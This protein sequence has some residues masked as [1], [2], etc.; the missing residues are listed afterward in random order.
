MNGFIIWGAFTAVVAGLCFWKPNPTRIFVGLF[1]AVMGLGIHGTDILTN[2]QAYVDFAR[3]APIPL[4]RDIGLALTEPNPRAFGVFMLVFETITSVLILSRGWYVKLGLLAGIAFLL[5]I[6]P[7]GLEEIPNAILAVGM[8]SL[9]RHEYSS[10]VMTMLTRTIRRNSTA[11]IRPRHDRAKRR[12]TRVGTAR[13]EMRDANGRQ[14][15]GARGEWLPSLAPAPGAHDH[16]EDR[17]VRA[18]VRVPTV[19]PKASQPFLKQ[20]HS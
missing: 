7:L 1:F 14:S 9:M 11:R 3:S 16:A 10:D 12:L 4:Y 17:V 6:T 8:A 5:A 18:S 15:E 19:V 2:P 20:P 13:F